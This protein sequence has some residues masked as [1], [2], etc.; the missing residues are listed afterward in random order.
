MDLFHYFSS[1]EVA[2]F[3]VVC[4][5]L[6]TI[7]GF[8]VHGIMGDRGFGPIPNGMIVFAGVIG[9]LAV[10][11]V[12]QGPADPRYM[13]PVAIAALVGGTCALIIM[14]LAKRLLGF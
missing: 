12:W 9:G 3:A 2:F 8:L 11:H 4:G 1:V 6:C 13:A 7:F 10:R 14:G 5:V